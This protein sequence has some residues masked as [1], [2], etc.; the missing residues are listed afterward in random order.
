[1][2]GEKGII[3]AIAPDQRQA[4]IVLGYAAAAFEQS[5]M[6]SELIANRTADALELAGGISIEVR[7]SNFRRLCG[8]TN[9]AVLAD[10]AAFWPTD[11][12]VDPDTEIINAVPPIRAP[13]ICTTES[14]SVMTTNTGRTMRMAEGGGANPQSVSPHRAAFEGNGEVEG[15]GPLGPFVPI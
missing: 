14:S 13:Q 11:E 9:I 3:L 12:S 6:L 2:P 8:T 1:M 7:A 15:T 5:S 10:E 4:S